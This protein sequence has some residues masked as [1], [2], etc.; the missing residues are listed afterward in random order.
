MSVNPLVLVEDARELSEIVNLRLKP[1]KPLSTILGDGVR[2]KNLLT[3]QVDV[4]T[5]VG[6]WKMA[7]FVNKDGVASPITRKN[8]N[9]YSIS[10]PCIKVKAPL[11]DSDVL[12]KL[13]AGT[14]NYET[15]G[16][17]MIQNALETIAEDASEMNEMI[18]L[19]EEWL[20]SQWLT[21]TISYEDTDTNVS[22]EVD[23]KKPAANTFTVPVLWDQ[24]AALISQ[25]IDSA[26]DIIQND[27]Q[28]PAPTLA[29]C[30]RNAAAQLKIRIEKGWLPF[31]K[32]DTNIDAG[33][34]ALRATYNELGMKLIYRNADGIEFWEVS[35]SLTDD[36]DV[37]TPIIRDDYIEFV[38]NGPTAKGD[39]MKYYGRKRGMS[40]L[41]DGTAVGERHARSWVDKDADTYMQEVQ[42]RP[43]F[44]AK[45][46][47]WY[48]SMKVI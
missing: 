23:T 32:T 29:L 34:A 10:T 14:L 22:W 39:R 42:T 15:M 36:K 4:H 24:E 19:R 48:V 20:W 18:A 35:G 16:D 28:G 25:D 1:R 45:H 43:F 46:P 31:I 47:Q 8:F 44:W 7:P 9:S 33:T 27:H 12:L 2:T 17:I 21:G 13:R 3:E 30:G 40:G 41:M 11:T 26:C 38:P 37:V 5:L 6:D